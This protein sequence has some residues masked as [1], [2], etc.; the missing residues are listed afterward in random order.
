M[1]IAKGKKLASEADKNPKSTRSDGIKG[2]MKRRVVFVSGESSMAEVV[3]QMR[4]LS[5]SS[6]LVVDQLL[7]VVGI[8]TERDIVHK[9]TLL[10]LKGKLNSKAFAMMNRPVMMAR[11]DHLYDDVRKYFLE[12]KIRHFPV[13]KAGQ[14][15][16]DI[17]GMITVTDMALAWLSAAPGQH[18]LPTIKSQIVIVV[19]ED[20]NRQL[21]TKLFKALSIEPLVHADNEMLIKMA[22]ELNIP[23]VV[24]LDGLEIEEIKRILARLKGH[25]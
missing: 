18:F 9:F 10:E 5:I 23:A 11:L 20:S 3:T 12:Q 4:D 2:L 16:S 6:V 17:V 24:D 14:K 22:I 13:T 7:E 25:G 21:Y 19:G 15:A 1:G 8:I